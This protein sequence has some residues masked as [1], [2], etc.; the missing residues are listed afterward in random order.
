MAVTLLVLAAIATAAVFHV[1]AEGSGSCHLHGDSAVAARCDR[2]GVD[3]DAAKVRWEVGGGFAVVARPGDKSEAGGTG[4]S[5][6][7]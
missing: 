5:G 2:R 3:R 1:D 4:T 6:D 7:A